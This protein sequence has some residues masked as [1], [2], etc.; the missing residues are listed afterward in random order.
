TIKKWVLVVPFDFQANALLETI[1]FVSRRISF[2]RV[3]A[4]LGRELLFLPASLLKEAIDAFGD[5]TLGPTALS[6][7]LRRNSNA[8]S[9]SITSCH[10]FG[11]AVESTPA[12]FRH[13]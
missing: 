4:Y 1:H 6:T 8:R 10:S 5:D 7:S 12:A 9:T 3:N 11:C 13:S 2:V